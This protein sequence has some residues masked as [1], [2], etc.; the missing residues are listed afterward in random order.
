L[1]IEPVEIL[2]KTA[3][4]TIMEADSR[5]WY[6]IQNPRNIGLAAPVQRL[7]AEISV[8]TE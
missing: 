3:G 4:Y 7:L 1:D 5:L 2:L 8:Q 6:K